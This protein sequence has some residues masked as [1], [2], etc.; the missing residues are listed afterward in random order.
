MTGCA[1]VPQHRL[2]GPPPSTAA[3]D[4]QDNSAYG[5]IGNHSHGTTTQ[6]CE[7]NASQDYGEDARQN[8]AA[9]R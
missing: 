6:Q 7:S 4:S 1:A 5:L 2:D 3:D 9:T 8:R